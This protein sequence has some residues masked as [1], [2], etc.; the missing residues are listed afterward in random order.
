M[1]HNVA[2]Y[3][4]GGTGIKNGETRSSSSRPRSPLLLCLRLPRRFSL[5][6]QL[7]H[8]TQQGLH[9]ERLLQKR[10]ARR[11]AVRK[12]LGYGMPDA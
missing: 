6:E 4:G 9:R 7:L 3:E 8:V 5:V 12:D 11:E 1:Q 10:G 2:F